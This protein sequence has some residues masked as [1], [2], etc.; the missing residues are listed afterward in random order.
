MSWIY[1]GLNLASP[2]KSFLSF[3]FKAWNKIINKS[4]NML[5]KLPGDIDGMADILSSV[6]VIFVGVGTSLVVLF[7]VIGFCQET[8]N[9]RDEM[10]YD[11]IVK[12]LV[13]LCMAEYFTIHSRKVLVSIL[14]CCKIFCKQ[15]KSYFN[16]S[17]AKLHITAAD[18]ELIDD[19]G[20]GTSILLLIVAVIIGVLL[21]I[22]AFSI[23][24]ATY[25]RMLKLLILIPFGSLAF[26]TMAGAGEVGRVSVSYLKHFMAI[27]LEAVTIS[28][29]LIFGTALMNY[30]ALDLGFK[31][32][33]LLVC[34]HLL[35]ML[36]QAAILTG[37]VK[38]AE[39]L[40]REMVGHY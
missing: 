26:A 3:A 6:N 38:G 29:A 14:R 5:T 16:K 36:F 7:F 15:L 2:I 39:H 33:W 12:Y 20:F 1:L 28:T 8:V 32:S 13:R 18:K 24:Y 31:D 35:S 21:I 22:M 19:C 40:T 17:N 37:T 9:V 23:L 11:S 4:Y 25:S 30:G 34:E 27:A 10:R